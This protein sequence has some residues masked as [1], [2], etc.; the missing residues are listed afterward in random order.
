MNIAVGVLADVFDTGTDGARAGASWRRVAVAIDATSRI[1]VGDTGV[2]ICVAGAFDGGV[3]GAA[4]IGAFATAWA[5]V[6]LGT[7]V[8]GVDCAAIADR[9]AAPVDQA[10]DIAGDAAFASADGIANFMRGRQTARASIR[11][12]TAFFRQTGAEAAGLVAALAVAR[13]VDGNSA[14]GAT[15]WAALLRGITWANTRLGNWIPC[16]PA[17][18]SG[19]CRGGRWPARGLGGSVELG[20]DHGCS[21]DTQQAKQKLPTIG[22]SGEGTR[23]R[24]ETFVVHNGMT[25]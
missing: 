18:A 14:L 3:A 11:G 20:A 23:E 2:G 13:S 9:R 21:A 4:E 19:W 6:A 17:R 1:V 25:P 7:A 12:A 5:E 15:V 10:A 16:L 8:V 22:A 24:V